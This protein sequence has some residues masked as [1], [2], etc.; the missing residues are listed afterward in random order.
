MFT[1]IKDASD[2]KK[3]WLDDKN[4][5]LIRLPEKDFIEYQYLATCVNKL[6]DLIQGTPFLFRP[7][8]FHKYAQYKR[9]SQQLIDFYSFWGFSKQDVIF[10]RAGR[11]TKEGNS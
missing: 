2:L 9:F 11:L 5:L 10:K 8:L 6:A 7:V 1:K 4:K 3:Q